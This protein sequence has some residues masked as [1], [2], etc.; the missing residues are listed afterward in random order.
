MSIGSISTDGAC[1]IAD[2]RIEK[3]TKRP[4][5]TELKN[6]SHTIRHRPEIYF[7]KLESF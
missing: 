4:V 2:K 5:E 7:F 3:L 6:M 1:F